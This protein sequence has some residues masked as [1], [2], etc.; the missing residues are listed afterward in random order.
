MGAHGY[1][2]PHMDPPVEP[3]GRRVGKAGEDGWDGKGLGFVAAPPLF[4][5]S[6]LF[7][8]RRNSRLVRVGEDIR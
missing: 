3:E 2:P 1:P 4:T 5:P 8:E 7:F 6:R